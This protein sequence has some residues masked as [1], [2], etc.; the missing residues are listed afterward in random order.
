MTKHLFV[1]RETVTYA[2]EKDMTV[3]E[4]DALWRERKALSGDE[5]RRFDQKLFDDLGLRFGE[6]DADDDLELDDL[7]E[8]KE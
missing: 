1:F 4:A 8:V 3:A 6:G 7:T 5:R 2:A